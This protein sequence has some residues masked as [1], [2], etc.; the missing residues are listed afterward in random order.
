MASVAGGGQLGHR[1]DWA[2]ED[3]EL[4]ILVHATALHPERMDDGG[5]WVA[6]DGAHGGYVSL[7]ASVPVGDGFFPAVSGHGGSAAAF[8]DQASQFPDLAVA[9][10]GVVV[11]HIVPEGI[12]VLAEGIIP[13]AGAGGVQGV[14]QVLWGVS[15]EGTRG[16]VG[17]IVHGCS[18]TDYTNEYKRGTVGINR[19]IYSREYT[20]KLSNIKPI[21]ESVTFNAVKEER[22]DGK[23][24]LTPEFKEVEEDCWVCDG[25]GKDARNPDGKCQT[26]NG[27]GKTMGMADS[28]PELNVSNQNARVVERM[29]GVEGDEDGMGVL[30]NEDIPA[31]LQRL[32]KLKN[33]SAGDGFTRQDVVSQGPARMNRDGDVPRIERGP[34]FYELGLDAGRV[35]VYLDRLIALLK[36]A[37]DHGLHVAWA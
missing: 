13:P 2:R 9:A 23:V 24:Y 5:Q 34:T 10:T 25:S 37:K 31:A 17:S 6:G 8:V 12:A 18:V 26:C 21:M 22:R 28:G 30:R 1:A 4:E 3:I 35:Q 11:A 32:I 15:T 33:T 7:D 29:L 27:S 19:F 14:L 16:D 36:H 20:M